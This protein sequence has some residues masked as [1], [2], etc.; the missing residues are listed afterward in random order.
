MFI[1]KKGHQPGVYVPLM[2]LFLVYT[3]LKFLVPLSIHEYC[4]KSFDVLLNNY[5]S[6]STST[7]L[8]QA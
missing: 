8:I 2:T 1:L 5:I 7:Y 3:R 4:T 6:K